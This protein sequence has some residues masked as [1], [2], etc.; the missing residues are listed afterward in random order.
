M[1]LKRSELVRKI[2]SGGKSIAEYC[3]S[4]MIYAELDRALLKIIWAADNPRSFSYFID[5][6]DIA[7]LMLSR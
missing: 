1:H 4:K 5:D 2:T 3:P 7:V 6:V